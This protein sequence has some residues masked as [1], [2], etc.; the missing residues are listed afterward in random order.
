MNLHK[1]IKENSINDNYKTLFITKAGVSV[2]EGIDDRHSLP[3]HSNIPNAVYGVLAQDETY[4][5]EIRIYDEN[6]DII[7]ELANHPKPITN[8]DIDYV[9]M[10]HYHTYKERIRQPGKRI[11]QHPEIENKYYDYIQELIEL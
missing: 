10:L 4:L 3:L 5:T 8:T 11:K 2:L 7:I 1:Y 9:C 6:G